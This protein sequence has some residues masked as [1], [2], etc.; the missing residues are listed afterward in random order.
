MRSCASQLKSSSFDKQVPAVSIVF[1]LAW[2]TV[3]PPFQAFS[4]REQG[5][6]NQSNR[7][8]SIET[9]NAKTRQAYN[10]AA[11]KYH[12]LFQDELKG[13]EYDRKLLDRFAA[14]FD[15]GSL[16]LDA[17]CGPSGHVG[18]YVFDKGIPVIGVDISDVCIQ[19]ARQ[20]NPGMRF[21]RCDMGDLPFEDE[22]FDGIIA[23][24]SIIDTPRDQVKRFFR[25]FERVLK[26]EGRLLVTVKAGTEEGYQSDLLGIEVEIY[27]ATFTLDEIQEYF[28][29]EAFEL[30][31]LEQR[32][33]YDFEIKSERIFAMGKKR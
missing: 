3:G 31:F 5:R 9:V 19:L 18:R 4:V 2:D 10:L 13:K 8:D 23:Y 6:I 14:D 22:V 7:M 1:S 28:D 26:P 17:G 12:E 30:E 29:A 11:H 15:E 24:Y 25:E 27:F 32:D 16:I 33:P 21:E 20:N